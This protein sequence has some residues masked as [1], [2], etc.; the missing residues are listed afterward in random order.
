MP[1]DPIRETTDC[2]E[3]GGR[4]FYDGSGATCAVCGGEGEVVS[5]EPASRDTQAGLL[6]TDETQHRSTE[7]TAADWL[8]EREAIYRLLAATE[9][10]RDELRRGWL[11]T[12]Q[13][14]NSCVANGVGC[15]AKRCGCVAEMEMLAD[16]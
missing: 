12:I 7:P 13:V 8:R 4:G 1:A 6:L 2:V 14:E 16:G 10:E 15:R 3:C 9:H 5:R 11:M